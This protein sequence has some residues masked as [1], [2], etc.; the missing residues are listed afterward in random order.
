MSSSCT[1]KIDV[2]RGENMF[3]KEQTWKDIT[4]AD[5]TNILDR[6]DVE[7][8][9]VRERDEV[10]AGRIAKAK[11]IPLSE[12]VER[13]KEIDPHKVTVCICRSGNR[14]SQACAYLSS[15]GYTKLY[16]MAGGMLEWDGD[17]VKG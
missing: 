12:L 3:I 9:D 15:L 6:D 5:M 13:V 4:P 7:F 14:S 8:I 1:K 2:K 11:N 17:I 16:N 10:Q